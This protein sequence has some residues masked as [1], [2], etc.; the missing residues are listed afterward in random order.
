MTKKKSSKK[1]SNTSVKEAK[2]ETNTPSPNE[3]ALPLATSETE[4]SNENGNSDQTVQNTPEESNNQPSSTLTTSETV[5]SETH[6]NIPPLHDSETSQDCTNNT[7]QINLST[8]TSGSDTKEE[9]VSQIN[10]DHHSTNP[11][12]TTHGSETSTSTSTLDLTNLNKDIVEKHENFLKN[13]CEI[14][15]QHS[16]TIVAFS[17]RLV[18]KFSQLDKTLEK[19]KEQTAKLFEHNEITKKENS[20]KGTLLDPSVQQMLMGFMTQVDQLYEQRDRAITEKMSKMGSNLQKLSNNVKVFEEAKKKEVSSEDK[21]LTTEE[22]VSNSQPTTSKVESN[23]EENLTE[24]ELKKRCKELEEKF[25]DKENEFSSYKTKVAEWKE[26]VKVI[27]NKD[28]KKIEELKKQVTTHEKTIEELNTKIEETN[29]KNEIV[30]NLENSLKIKDD[31]IENLK[32]EVTSLA[33]KISQ[34][35][36]VIEQHQTTIM[37]KN[38]ICSELCEKLDSVQQQQQEAAMSSAKKVRKLQ[39]LKILKKLELDSKTW[40]YVHHSVENNLEWID[41]EELKQ[42][43]LA[44]QSNSSLDSLLPE[45]SI[46]QIHE[47][48]LQ[49]KLSEESKKLEE[50]IKLFNEKDEELKTYK[51]RAHAALKKKSDALNQAKIDYENQINELKESLTKQQEENEEQ[52]KTIQELQ[53]QVQSFIIIQEKAVKLGSDLD[54][55]MSEKE[56]LEDKMKSLEKQLSKTKE[57]FNEEKS[58]IVEDYELQ[59]RQLESKNSELDEQFRKELR[60]TRERN[61]RILDEKE[62]EITK[63]QMKISENQQVTDEAEQVREKLVSLENEMNL[64]KEENESLKKQLTA[65]MT[66]AENTSTVRTPRKMDQAQILSSALNEGP[67]TPT[68]ISQDNISDLSPSVSTSDLTLERDFNQLIELAQLQASR[69]TEMMHYKETI[70]K[71]KQVIKEREYSEKSFKI[72]EKQLKDEI[73]HLQRLQKQ[74]APNL[75]YLKNILISFLTGEDRIVKEKLLKVLAQIMDLSKEEQEKI[76]QKCLTEPSSSLWNIF[77]SKK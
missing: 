29:K 10:G 47:E 58:K 59:L 34:K 16:G 7:P 14:V 32:K 22:T 21:S 44:A 77:G 74:G 62:R 28:M 9:E 56:D 68:S 30:P 40:F 42:I 33:E 38:Q 53:E 45:K 61:R 27:S 70:S 3:S 18:D 73:E 6:E 48:P 8:A 49:L 66:N 46:L 25:K 54:K 52:S 4:A 39:D 31:E 65:M 12:S 37:E 19:S 15:Q 17:E 64:I 51:T 26:K 36:L 72:L 76:S 13:V 20:Q 5:S 75:E 67:T 71:L 50:Q 11:F 35:D 57:D 43:H 55:V 1:P 63:L 60:I 2:Q 41:L 24:E 23:V 69:D